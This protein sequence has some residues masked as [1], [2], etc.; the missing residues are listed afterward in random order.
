MASTVKCPECGTEIGSDQRSR[1]K[2]AVSCFHL[3]DKGPVQVLAEL[4]NRD[5]EYS[6]RVRQL[7]G[8]AKEAEA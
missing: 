1:Y 6:Y 3:P 5:D 8:S 2:H 4:S 7:L